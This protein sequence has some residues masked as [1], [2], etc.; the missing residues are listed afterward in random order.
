MKRLISVALVFVLAAAAWAQDGF[1][2]VEKQVVEFNLKNGLKFLVLPRH[3]APVVSFHTYVSIGAVNEDRGITGLAHIFEH[4]AFK[5]TTDIGTNEKTGGYAKEKPSLETLDKAWKAFYNESIKPKPDPGLFAKYKMEYDTALA[6]ASRLND[7]EEFGRVIEQNGGVGLNATT[8][9]DATQYFYSLPSNKIELWFSLE[10][11]RFYDP[12]IRDFYKEKDVVMEERRMRTESNPIGKLIEEVL[13][14]A[15][16][17]HPYKDPVVGHMADLKGIT[18]TE[19][20]S[21]YRKYYVPEN[22]TIAI[23]G[24]VDVN[25]VKR[26]AEIYFGRIPAGQKTEQVRTVE[27]PQI[28]ERKVVLHEQSQ[29][30]LLVGYKKGSALDAD[31]AVYDVISDLLSS[32]RTSRLYKSLVRDKKIAVQAGGFSGF[33]GQ[34]YPNLFLFLAVPAQGK[35]NDTCLAAINDEIIK[36]KTELVSDEELKAIKTRQRANLIRSLGSNNGLARQLTFYQGLMD[37]W[38]EMFK[39]LDKINAVKAEDMKRVAEKIFQPNNCTIGTIEP[40]K[41]N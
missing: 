9:A 36:L 38:R 6:R 5:G 32:G 25:E 31:D 23:V 10:S 20:L 26:L 17:A 7:S 3:E 28:G 34:R 13:A 33:P 40:V 27:P 19:A 8:G 4:L 21:F 39:S 24:D 41:N 35:S 15:F 29:P 30:I 2:D 1:K 16:K 14:V 11:A 37:D 22:M 12:I 18:R